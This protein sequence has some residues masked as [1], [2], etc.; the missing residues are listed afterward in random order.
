MDEVE[1]YLA[2]IPAARQ[3]DARA[4]SGRMARATGEPP[5]LWGTM[6]GF[7]DHHYRY[8]SGRE[9]DTFR[10]GFAPRKTALVIYAGCS[11]SP[12]PALLDRLGKH[13]TGAGCVYL[14]KLSDADA[15]VLDEVIAWAY[16]ASPPRS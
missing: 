8:G 16:A 9:G 7:G 5:R 11:Q 15:G 3:A 12:P 14:K 6:I 2:G 10:V 1:T 4:L 13:T